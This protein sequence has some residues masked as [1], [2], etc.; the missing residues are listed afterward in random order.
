MVY[1]ATNATIGHAK[2]PDSRIMR[3][4][5]VMATQG[6]TRQHSKWN[7]MHTVSFRLLSSP[8]SFIIS[9]RD[10]VMDSLMM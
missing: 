6:I 8:E 2:W 4:D 1:A 5:I 3:H 9:D 7:G 10:Y